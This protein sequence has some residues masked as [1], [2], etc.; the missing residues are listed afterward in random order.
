MET[1]MRPASHIAKGDVILRGQQKC[2][3]AGAANT[4]DAK[5]TITYLRNGQQ[6]L[7]IGKKTD[8]LKVLI[9]DEDH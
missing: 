7:W 3:V 1:E 2:P 6:E 5:R 4:S 8:Q 9:S